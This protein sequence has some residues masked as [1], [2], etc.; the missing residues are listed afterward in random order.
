MVRL[1][2]NSL[3][4]WRRT[5]YTAECCGN[6]LQGRPDIRPWPIRTSRMHVR[7]CAQA[8]GRLSGSGAEYAAE[9]AQTKDGAGGGP[10]EERTCAWGR[11]MRLLKIGGVADSDVSM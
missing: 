1:V 11:G 4:R 10:A 5:N 6:L 9:K 8:I 2:I 3:S 7:A